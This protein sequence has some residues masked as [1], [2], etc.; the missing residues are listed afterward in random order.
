MIRGVKPFCLK[1]LV[2]PAGWIHAEIGYDLDI[3]Y[4]LLPN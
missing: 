2:Q 3:E 4:E 1:N